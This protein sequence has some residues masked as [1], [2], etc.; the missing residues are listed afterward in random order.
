MPPPPAATITIR[1]T[2]AM[3]DGPKRTIAEGIANDQY[4]FWLGSGISR[5]RMPDLSD[6]AKNVLRTLQSRI[7]QADPACR[8]RRALSS[9]I[10]LAMPSPDEWAVI[11]DRQA[12]DL[13][14]VLDTLARR[15]VGNYARMLNVTVDGE[16]ADFLLWDVLD[17]A[18]VYSNP[19]IEP[20]AEHLCLAALAIEGVASEMPS[21]NWDPLLE[22]AVAN[23]AEASPSCGWLWRRRRP[24]CTAD[25]RTS[26]SSTVAR[27]PPVRTPVDIVG[28]SWHGRTRSTGGPPTTP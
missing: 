21:A 17:A 14:P 22:R 13:W 25:E 19:A 26:T 12:A 11:D 9:V 16:E 1:E 7:D 8:Y 2:L 18:S 4:V 5:A 23:L 27:K 10:N 20:D 3:L 15:L 28:S 6:L 24:G